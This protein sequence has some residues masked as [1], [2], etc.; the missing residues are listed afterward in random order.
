MKNLF[1]SR[2][3]LL[4]Q[5]SPPS[6]TPFFQCSSRRVLFVISRSR[7]VGTVGIAR[8]HTY[9]HVEMPCSLVYRSIAMQFTAPLLACDA[10]YYVPYLP[11]AFCSDRIKRGNGF[12]LLQQTS[13]ISPRLETYMIQWGCTG[14]IL[15]CHT[16]INATTF[17]S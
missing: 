4:R 8:H 1:A 12:S 2:L 17:P 10:V 7:M 14:S 11:I 13:D 3:L 9:A 5:S 15:F 6:P 16:Y